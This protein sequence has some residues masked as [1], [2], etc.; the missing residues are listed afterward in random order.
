MH[1]R[2]PGRLCRFQSLYRRALAL[3]FALAACGLGLTGCGKGPSVVV[4]LSSVPPEAATLRIVTNLEGRQAQELPALTTT[5][6]E[7]YSFGLH[8]PDG[9]SGSAQISVGAYNASNC[10]LST[11]S[12]AVP[13][14][15]E[16]QTLTLQLTA[17]EPEYAASCK[18]SLPAIRRVVQSPT[19]SG[20]RLLIDGFGFQPKSRVTVD[21]M[22]VTGFVF[23]S[24]ERLEID[25]PAIASP[26]GKRPIELLVVN[27]DTNFD[28]IKVDLLS[29]LFEDLAANTYQ[30]P[31]NYNPQAVAL[32]DVSGDGQLDVMVT[33]FVDKTKGF[34]A[35]YLNTG[36]GKLAD[37]VVY[38]TPGTSH[39]IGIADVNAN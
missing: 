4:S 16:E 24:P 8:Y 26:S 5:G 19:A 37:P 23:K 17:P 39:G 7:R 2:D 33:G 1:R 38:P 11:V 27:P 18:R 21:G 31:A 35:V 14:T 22:A 20:R 25:E 12:G 34:V 28:A 13:L 10:L 3:G 15:P 9:S 6:Q 36:S 32:G 29:V 30:L